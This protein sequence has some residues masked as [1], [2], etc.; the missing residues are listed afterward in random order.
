M[1]RR[2]A[3]PFRGTVELDD[4][5]TWPEREYLAVAAGTVA[6]IGLGFKPFYRFSEATPAG[7]AFHVLGIHASP[8]A[9]VAE[10]P[11]VHAGKPM[12][13]GRAYDAVSRG[14][15]VKSTSGPTRYMIDGDLHERASGIEVTIG[16][17]VRL[18]V[19]K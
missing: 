4:G 14:M 19:L 7:S 15:R 11:R 18:V 8:S 6:H 16:P 10:L 1:I 17:A 5:T 2:M 9:F 3:A 12:R 13:S